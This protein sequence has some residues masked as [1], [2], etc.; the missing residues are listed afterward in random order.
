MRPTL[1]LLI[2]T[3]ACW[4]HSETIVV[5]VQEDLEKTPP[6][7]E[8]KNY[9]SEALAKENIQVSYLP[10]SL[11]RGNFLANKGEISGE[12]IRT[13]YVLK[14][15]PNLM[16]TSFP[17]IHT[18]FRVVHRKNIKKFDE[19]KL[20]S[21]VGVVFFNSPAVRATLEKKKLKMEVVTTL[22]QVV[23]LLASERADYTILPDT[24]IAAARDQKPQVFQKFEVSKEVF[25]RQGLY[26]CLNKK[27]AALM[28][29]IE[30]ALSRASRSPAS[31]YR[32]LPQLLNFEMP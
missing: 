5:S 15:S 32:Y 25:D 8:L 31:K 6:I 19:N 27:H 10:F 29:K 14:T 4:A 13:D 1:F 11:E 2:F 23:L 20:D 22:E 26:F 28:P 17:I 18:N 7:V 9:V 24:I 3:L 30:R 21:Y 12:L 16:T